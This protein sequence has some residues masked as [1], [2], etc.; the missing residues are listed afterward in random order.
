LARLSH[1]AQHGAAGFQQV[2]NVD[3]AIAIPIEDRA[4]QS[5]R[6]PLRVR[7]FLSQ[8]V[9]QYLWRS[10]RLRRCIRRCRCDWSRCG[11]AMIEHA[12]GD[13][14]QR[15]RRKPAQQHLRLVGSDACRLA[16]RLLRARGAITEYVTEDLT[17]L[18]AAADCGAKHAAD[19]LSGVIALQGAVQIIRALRLAR[20]AAKRA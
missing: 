14:R 11:L 12:L 17:T 5:A 18:S 6:A 8:H 15:D 19:V 9:T 4:E 2:A 13:V 7:G 20:I 1:A 3:F 10:G 16:H